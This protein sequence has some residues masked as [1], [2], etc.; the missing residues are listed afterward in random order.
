GAARGRG[1]ALGGGG[2]GEVGGRLTS[3]GVAGRV[4]PLLRRQALLQV[5]AGPEPAGLGVVA[6]TQRR[7]GPGG[8]SKGEAVPRQQLTRG[9]DQG[10]EALEIGIEPEG[11]LERL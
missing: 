10:R 3:D 2:G 7:P 9:G 8:L 11:S 5:G 1:R 6:G 4:R